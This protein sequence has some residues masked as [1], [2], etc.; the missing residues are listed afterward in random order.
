MNV[1]T[2]KID[3]ITLVTY[4]MI[5]INFFLQ[6]KHSKDRFFEE[7]FLMADTSIEV[8]LGILFIFLSNINIRF[9]EI[10]LE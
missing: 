6:D 8:V 4:G 2:Q 3:G 5:V 9:A 1:S 10:E 7:N